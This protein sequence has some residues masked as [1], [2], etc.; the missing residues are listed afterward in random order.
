MRDNKQIWNPL[1]TN[2]NTAPRVVSA[3]VRVP[4]PTELGAKIKDERLR[5]GMTQNDVAQ[6]I[7]CPSW[8][9][10]QVERSQMT[11][12]DWLHDKIVALAKE[13]GIL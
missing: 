6:Q 10:R 4:L 5:R 8:C 2:Y 13:W 1:G 11:V 9:I 7:D 12:Q 3:F